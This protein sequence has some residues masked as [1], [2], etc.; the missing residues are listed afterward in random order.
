MSTA[1]ET[2][3]R[4]RPGLLILLPL[5]VFLALAS[6]FLYRLGSGVSGAG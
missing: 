2:P 6:L 5:I 1:S 3:G 4:R